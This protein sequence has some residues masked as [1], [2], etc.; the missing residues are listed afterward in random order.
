MIDRD[1]LYAYF[2][3]YH[4]PVVPSTNGWYSCRC[5]ICD[6][7]KFAVNFTY[8]IGKCWRG[9]FNGFVIDAIRI[10]HGIDSFEA[11]ELID[12]METELIKVPVVI[13][14]ID[15]EAR[16]K[17][18][19]GY[20][21]ILSGDTSLAHR[22]R[23]YLT[24]RGFDLNY[25]DRIGV[26]YCN[27]A[28]KN[29]K[30]N[31]LGYIIIPFKKNGI[32]TYFIG[33]DYIGNFLR[34]KNPSKEKYGTGKMEVLFNEEALFLQKKIY[35]TE[36][37]ACAAT[38]KNQ[39]VSIQG[40]IPSIIQRNIIVKSDV[41]EVIIVPDAGFYA[42]GLEAGRDI[43]KHKKVKVLNLDWF[44]DNGI[45]KDVNEIGV[46]NVQG[47]EDRTPWMDH[48][49]LYHQFKVYTSKRIVI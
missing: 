42:N 15:K 18:P 23:N 44:K 16:I 7:E 36:G 32:L 33:R 29:P 28:T 1:K 14:K 12:S 3:S 40:S 46:E 30:D 19:D 20:H 10:Y 6:K 47:V 22:A 49:F 43:M 37:W 34:Y 5:P 48:K 2:N 24:D 45:G 35:L 21:P 13:S 38:M 39:G 31:Y 25:L 41:E 9:C 8:L 26:G 11:R 27:E 17:L 4:G